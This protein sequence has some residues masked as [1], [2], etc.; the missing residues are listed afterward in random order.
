VPGQPRTRS[1]KVCRAQNR[2]GLPCQC[3]LLLNG[4][5]CRFHGGK[6][7]TNADRDEITRKTG[8]TFKKTGPNTPEGM[9]RSYAA[10]DAGRARYLQE[11][12]ERSQQTL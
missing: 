6:S 5:R 10:R 9:A 8:R 11:R 12:R 2:K 4:N 7:L 3:K 1:G